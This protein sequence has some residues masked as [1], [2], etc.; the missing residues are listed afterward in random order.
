[1]RIWKA[2]A[3]ELS[4]QGYLGSLPEEDGAHGAGT[5][6]GLSTW[7]SLAYPTWRA[8]IRPREQHFPRSGGVVLTIGETCSCLR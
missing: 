1:M 7:A 3:F 5:K 2:A 4:V 6:T 8:S